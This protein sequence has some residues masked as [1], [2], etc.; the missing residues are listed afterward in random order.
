WEITVSRSASAIC[1][2]TSSASSGGSAFASAADWQRC[3]DTVVPGFTAGRAALEP[4]MS[5]TDAN[6]MRCGSCLQGCPTN[7]GKSTQNTYI[8]RAWARGK[9]ELRAE[10]PVERVVIEDRGD[11]LEATGVEYRDASGE[12]QRTDAGAVVVAA[13]TLNTP[14]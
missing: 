13:G 1:S 10:S 3:I 6:C 4:V 11:G 12:L 7:A 2:L 9:L 8:H 5:Y 14:Q